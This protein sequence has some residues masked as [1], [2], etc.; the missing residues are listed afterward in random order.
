MTN[1]LDLGQLGEKDFRE[2]PS[3]LPGPSTPRTITA[4]G[5]FAAFAA[6][7]GWTPAQLAIGLG[8]R[9]R[10]GYHPD[11]RHQ[12]AEIPAGKCR[13]R[14]YQPEPADFRDINN[15]L[16]QYPNVG[17]RYNESN[18]RFVDKNKN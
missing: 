1:T 12:T 7:K 18:K 13:R 8:A 11:T 4:V 6:Q 10:L 2:S 9:A 15:L 17:D 16:A 5:A 14:G 3:P